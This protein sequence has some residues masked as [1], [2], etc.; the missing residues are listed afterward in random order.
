MSSVLQP[1]GYDAWLVGEVATEFQES[2]PSQLMSIATP[3]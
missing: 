1:Y 3:T 2:L